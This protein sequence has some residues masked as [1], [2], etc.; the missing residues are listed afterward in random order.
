MSA[1]WS[2]HGSILEGNWTMHRTPSLPATVR[3]PNKKPSD[4]PTRIVTYDLP[5]MF[6]YSG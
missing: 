2:T 4:A 6:A 1:P 5:A 3:Q